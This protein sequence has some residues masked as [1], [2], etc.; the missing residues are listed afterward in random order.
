MKNVLTAL[1]LGTALATVL[2][3]WGHSA[4]MRL[5][6]RAPA[7][8]YQASYWDGLFIGI[9]GGYGQG[10][11]SSGDFSSPTATGFLG[12]L[13]AGANK[14]VGSFVFGMITDIDIGAIDKSGNKLAWLGT[15]RG[16]AGF[17]LTPTLW[18]YGT[19][20]VAYGGVNLGT[21]QNGNL[22]ADLNGFKMPTVGYAFG[23][24]AE[25]A[26]SPNWGLGVE[27]LHVNLSGPES[28]GFSSKAEGDLFRGVLNY[29]F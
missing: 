10:S 7:E 19:G 13:Q 9:N 15:T 3:T 2:G 26:L 21:I 5:Q 17:L 4:D 27:Y 23:A 28:P 22:V 20:G 11:I 29:K 24:G 8:Q 18:V 16:K 12:G 14:Q 1:A 6:P 25:Y